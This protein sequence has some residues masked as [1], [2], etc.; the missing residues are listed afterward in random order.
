MASNVSECE[1]VFFIFEKLYEEIENVLEKHD[2]QINHKTI[3][4][5][6]FLE[7]AILE[8]LRMCGPVN[9]SGRY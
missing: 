3:N 6:H 4:E 1:T 5:M 2:G 9:Q 7:A 8:N